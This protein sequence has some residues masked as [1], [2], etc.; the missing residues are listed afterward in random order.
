MKIL[1]I[2]PYF[3]K[4]P[5]WFDAFLLSCEKNPEVTWLVPTDCELPAR[6]P[7]NVIFVPMTLSELCEDA[8]NRLGVDIKYTRPYK[9]C[10]LRPA[11]GL[12][13]EKYLADYQFWGHCDFDV[14]FGRIRKF[15][16]D[17]MLSSCDIISSRRERVAGHFTL[18]RNSGDINQL[19]YMHPMW[20]KAMESEE[21]FYF[22]EVGMTEVVNRSSVNV[23]WGD[24]LFNTRKNDSPGRLPL[25][26]NVFEWSNGCVTNLRT[27]EEV[28][29]VNF[30]QWKDWIIKSDV[31]Y[32]E[33]TP[34]FYLSYTHFSVSPA[35][36]PAL[37]S[38]HIGSAAK[39]IKR[40]LFRSDG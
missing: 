15:V 7:G 27:G 18:Y 22:D 19:F 40:A 25:R 28:M 24:Y 9:V 17:D 23:C 13:F 16:T 5:F 1:L 38:L 4:F 8:S 26:L 30:M 34:N 31:Q 21:S 10:D 36:Y 11:F 3:G 14:I 20:R 37:R 35:K 32:G 12:I 6:H 2:N 29:Y 39:M 33:N